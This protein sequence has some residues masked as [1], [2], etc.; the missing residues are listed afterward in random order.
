M[1]ERIRELAEQAGWDIGD[2]ACGFTTRLEKFHY[3]SIENI[4]AEN[5]RMRE[6]A[7]KL[8]AEVERLLTTISQIE[9]MAAGPLC[10][11]EAIHSVASG[12]LNAWRN[13]KLVYDPTCERTRKALE[14]AP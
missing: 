11:K 3:L 8:R 5:E 9:R 14:G 1:N 13:P 6:E 4:R 7:G 12:A 10:S 2:E